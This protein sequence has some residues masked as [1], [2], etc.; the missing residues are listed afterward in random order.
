MSMF[1]WHNCFERVMTKVYVSNLKILMN[2]MDDGDGYGIDKIICKLLIVISK[3]FK[4]PC[5]KRWEYIYGYTY[6]YV[7]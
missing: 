2:K 4:Y 3:F 1:K 5:D 7:S 6:M